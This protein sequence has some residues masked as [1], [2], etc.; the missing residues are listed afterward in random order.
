M[1]SFWELKLHFYWIQDLHK[2]VSN[3][4]PISYS[5]GRIIKQEEDGCKTCCVQSDVSMEVRLKG[6]C[7]SCNKREHESNII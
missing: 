2:Q 7:V 4:P 5:R 6:R 1:Y 3:N